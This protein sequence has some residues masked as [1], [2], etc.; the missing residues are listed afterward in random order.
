MDI[1]YRIGHGYDAHRLVK[2]R[3]LI[4]G[5]VAVSFD[6]GLDGHSDADVLTHA[7]IDALLGAAGLGDIGLHFPD[8]QSYYKDI[9]SI[10]LLKQACQL[11]KQAG[12]SVANIDATVVAQSP[13]L[14]PYRQQMIANL[15]DAV[16]ADAAAINVKATTEEGMGFSGQGLGMAAYAVCLIYKSQ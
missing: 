8:T 10:I 15:S 12:W 9:S 5:G 14:A 7:I 13:K 16:Q 1:P 4:L 2:D 11:V 6:R 3:P